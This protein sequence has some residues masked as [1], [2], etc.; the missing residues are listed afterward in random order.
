MSSH[1]RWKQILVVLMTCLVSASIAHTQRGN[2]LAY[3]TPDGIVL[4]DLA[5]NTTDL[6]TDEYHAI[7]TLRWS[8]DGE[9]L[10]FS[11]Q[12][13][14]REYLYIMDIDTRAVTR[15]VGDIESLVAWMPDGERLLFTR[16][17]EPPH[18]D[19]YAVTLDDGAEQILVED[20][21]TAKY[22]G[23]FLS[24][25]GEQLVFYSEIDRLDVDTFLISSPNLIGL[26]PATPDEMA[27]FLPDFTNSLGL[28]DGLTWTPDRSHLALIGLHNAGWLVHI[29]PAGELPRSI[30]SGFRLI[31]LTT[32]AW[33]PEGTRLAFFD[34]TFV[35]GCLV[36]VN[37]QG[38]QRREMTCSDDSQFGPDLAWS[39][40]GAFLL[41]T[42]S[43]LTS[44]S[45]DDPVQSVRLV[46]VDRGLDI[47]LRDISPDARLFT[48][49]PVTNR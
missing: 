11:A 15:L 25:D 43:V 44:S 20:A 49:R 33:H 19:I 24:P 21:I 5:T 12:H 48:W 28:V 34:E 45:S 16:G 39:P 46:D 35:S 29:A 30:S 2:Q 31:S 18:S 40:D 47:P 4:Y 37:P 3:V 36:T 41:Y 6:L 23:P 27:L 26:N 42:K 17:T 7:G 9:Q 10:A 14:A 8:P 22:P 38:E 13:D 1:P 32:P